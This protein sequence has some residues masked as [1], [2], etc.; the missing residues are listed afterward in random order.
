[1]TRCHTSR[2]FFHDMPNAKLA[3][4]VAARGV[5]QDLDLEAMRETEFEPLLT[6]GS[7]A[8]SRAGAHGMSAG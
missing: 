5:L 7:L 8:R 4:Y 6:C 2:D 1:M 3:R